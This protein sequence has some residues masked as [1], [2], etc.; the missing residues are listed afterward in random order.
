MSWKIAP[1]VAWQ[2]IDG[3]AVVVDL[4]SGTT[5]GLNPSATLVWTEVAGDRTVS[6][7]EEVARAFE[8]DAESAERDCAAFLAE[9]EQ[10]AFLV[11]TE[12]PRT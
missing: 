10:R 6:L 8:I 12:S 5:I 1:H 11:H 7:A 4:R 2:V 3:S 9:M